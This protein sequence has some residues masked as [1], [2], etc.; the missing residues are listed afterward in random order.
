MIQVESIEYLGPTLPLFTIYLS[1]V[2][3]VHFTK[4][5]LSVLAN[6][7][8]R[9]P[10]FI[11][12]DDPVVVAIEPIEHLRFSPPLISGNLAVVVCVQATE[13]VRAAMSAVTRLR[14]RVL[15]ESCK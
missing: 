8:P 13:K 2:I 15:A 12:T 14:R 10:S 1:V 6:L 3:R 4:A 5:H 7:A 9:L 11:L